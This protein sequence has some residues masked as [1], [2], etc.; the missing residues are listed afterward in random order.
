MTGTFLSLD[1]LDGTGKS[2]Q[3]RLLTEWL[4]GQ[5][6]EV[7]SCRDPGGTSAGDEI[8]RLLLDPHSNIGSVCEMFLYMSSRAQ[9]VD[10]VIAPALD[11]GNVVLC[12]RFLLST[13]VYQG[14]AAGLDPEMIREVGKIATRG[15]LPDWT[16]VLDLDP[17]A[18]A[19]RRQSP[20][21][22][23]EARSDEFHGKVRAGFL[24]EARR[25]PDRIRIIEASRDAVSV[26]Q[27]IV[28]RLNV[29]WAP[30]VGHDAVLMQLR[31]ALARGRLGHAFLFV[32]P[33]GIGKRRA[34]SH[35]AQGL[36]CEKHS[37]A[38]LEP[39]G[40]C[41]GC[42][43]V[44]EDAHPDFFSVAKP[45]D[46]HEMPIQVIQDL[47][48][49]L[50]LKPARGRYKIAIVDDADLLNEE[51]ANCFLKTLEEPPPASLLILL[52]SSAETQLATIVSRCQILRFQELKPDV[53]ADL[54]TRLGVTE[55]R[56]EAKRLA[57]W[58]TGS[59]GRA[60]EMAQEDWKEARQVLLD[61]L[62][63]SPIRSTELASKMQEFIDAA[64]KEAAPRRARAK[65]V[66]RLAADLFRDG[67][68]AAS[69]PEVH[70]SID[71]AKANALAQRLGEDTLIDLI[72]RCL[73]A[74]YH[75]GRFLNQTLAIDCWMDDLAQI[76]A[77]QFVQPVGASSL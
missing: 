64:S 2:T 10:E 31:R 34:A 70:F 74:D 45:S 19:A 54:L 57:A 73:Q 49:R 47:C 44:E 60:M 71:V 65:Q 46:K 40:Q 23:I 5:G 66:I 43:Q 16:G 69:G 33:S 38:A 35:V 4:K 21:D 28:K 67:L 1:G 62:S 9:L 26:H 75:I 41:S 48:E 59:V 29:S 13:V 8:R 7:T 63:V 24:L 72:D 14:H 37:P 56:S 61:G 76:A 55:D 39:C 51:A 25:D 53:I 30:L 42:K 58:G 27:S 6:H 68:A 11:R 17:A 36:L 12:D 3:L 15:V 52:A 50:S 18:A 22:R 20:P 32:G 77:G